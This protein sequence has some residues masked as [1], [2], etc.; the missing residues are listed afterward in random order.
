LAELP[1]SDEAR[2]LQAAEMREQQVF[3]SPSMYNVYDNT[4]GFW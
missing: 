1:L 3:L 2:M 4:D